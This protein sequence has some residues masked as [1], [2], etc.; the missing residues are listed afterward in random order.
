V[1]EINI[2]LLKLHVAKRWKTKITREESMFFS[3]HNFKVSDEDEKQ[4]VSF[5]CPEMFNAE[6]VKLVS[7][8]FVSSSPLPVL[9][10]ASNQLPEGVEN[11]EDE[12]A[13]HDGD[14]HYHTTFRVG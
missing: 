13:D 10:Q 1:G 6:L 4:S 5:I 9:T 11:E 2:L 12:Q 7:P 8:N 3:K 14:F